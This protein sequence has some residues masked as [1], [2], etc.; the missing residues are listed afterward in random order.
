[1]EPWL[2]QGGGEVTDLYFKAMGDV[3][4]IAEDLGADGPGE[5]TPPPTFPDANLRLRVGGASTS[6][7][8]VDYDTANL[9]TFESV[10]AVGVPIPEPSSII[11]LMATFGIFSGLGH[12]AYRS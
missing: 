12:R 5:F 6:D 1:M 2:S 8:F 4:T 7:I 10:M 11:L 9:G 3:F